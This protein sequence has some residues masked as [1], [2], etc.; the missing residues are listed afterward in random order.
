[1]Y[2]NSEWEIE[3]NISKEYSDSAESF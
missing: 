2:M 3:Y 1:M